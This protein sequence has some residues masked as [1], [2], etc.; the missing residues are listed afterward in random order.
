MSTIAG[1]TFAQACTDAAAL[2]LD[3]GQLQYTTAFLMPFAAQVYSDLETAFSNEGI[4]WNEFFQ[5]LNY[6]ANQT[7]IDTSAIGNLYEPKGMWQRLT[8]ND[9]WL[10][11]RKRTL[12]P[13]PPVLPSFLGEWWWS[14]A[15]NGTSNVLA[16]NGANQN[17]LI[18]VHVEADL[19]YPAANGAIGYDDFYWCIVFG[20]AALAA[21]PTGRDT[22]ALKNDARYQKRLSAA[23]NRRTRL[24]QGVVRRPRR[25]SR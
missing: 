4:P 19:P 16:V 12:P 1:R 25:Y 5:T 18:L 22:L 3:Q 17:L 13:P 6:V 2:L 15:Q 10:P 24:Q 23:L 7:T 11:V 20:I 9:V 21:D 14:A 8:A